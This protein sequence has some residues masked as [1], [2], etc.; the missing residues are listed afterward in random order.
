[1]NPKNNVEITELLNAVVIPDTEV[2]LRDVGRVKSVEVSDHECS[3]VIELGFYIESDQIFYQNLFSS[4]VSSKLGDRKIS[5]KID[6]HIEPHG[7]QPTLAPIKGVKN[8]IA[9]TAGKGGVG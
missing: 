2:T 8:I 6:S 7:V 9:I 1:M 5:I 4:S 3:I